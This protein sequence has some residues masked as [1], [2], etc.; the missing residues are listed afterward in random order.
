[1]TL[2]FPHITHL[3]NSRLRQMQEALKIKENNYFHEMK[4]VIL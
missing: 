2:L 1:M 3:Q 4:G